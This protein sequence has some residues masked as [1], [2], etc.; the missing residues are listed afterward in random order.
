MKHSYKNARYQKGFSLIELL[1]AMAIIAVLLGLVGFG[2]ATAQRNSRDAT[3][4]QTISDIRVG[5]EDYLLKNNEYPDAA[6]FGY[7]A[8]TEE[9][10]IGGNNDVQVV[11]PMSSGLLTPVDDETTASGT[12]F[13]YEKDGS[14]GAYTLGSQLETGEFYHSN[15]TESV[16]STV[17]DCD[18][19][20]AILVGTTTNNGSPPNS[21]T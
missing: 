21:N 7:S 16:N 8:S 20:E 15:N 19:G 10:T 11:I 14:G 12:L 2:I 9:I 4:R 18:A 5:I 1:V 6:D 3:R 17:T 13:C